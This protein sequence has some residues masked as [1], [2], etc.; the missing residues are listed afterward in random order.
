MATVTEPFMT[1]DQTGQTR[2]SFLQAGAGAVLVLTGVGAGVLA[3]P[4]AAGSWIHADP[5]YPGEIRLFAGNYV[6]REWL[7]C[8][9]ERDDAPDLRGRAVVGAGRVP[10]GPVY[11]RG[12]HG[13]GIAAG[14][15]DG[16]RSTL[17]LTYLASPDFRAEEPLIAEIRCFAFDFAPEGWAMCDGRELLVN[18]NTAL[19]SILGTRFGGND[20]TTFALPDLRG[21]TPV[22][23]GDGPGLPPEPDAHERND[24]DPGGTGR[25]PRLHLT[26]C[27]ALR[28]KYP[29]RV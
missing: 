20:K 10:E 6:P 13:K 16:H 11:E 17:A 25:R 15:R 24:L 14:R 23:R 5:I 29:A 8:H 27:I 9:G 1:D 4:A 3:P 22:D 7:A 12:E 19:Y 21:L 28:G 26:Y 18:N 2:R